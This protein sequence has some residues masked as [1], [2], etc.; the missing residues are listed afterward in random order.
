MEKIICNGYAYYSDGKKI[1]RAKEDG[2]EAFVL[3]SKHEKNKAILAIKDVK[4]GYVYFEEIG[5]Y[6]YQSDWQHEAEKTYTA[7]RV[8]TDE[9]LE[10]QKISYREDIRPYGADDYV[11]G[12][13]E[14]YD[15]PKDVENPAK[16]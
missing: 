4:D 15:P 13:P 16:K 5:Y 6:T 10:L 14:T 9:S 3:Y 11:A 7:Y 8:K 1:F 2:T 12:T